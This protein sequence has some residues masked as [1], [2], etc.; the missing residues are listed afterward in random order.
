MKQIILST[1]TIESIEQ[2]SKALKTI[3]DLAVNIMIKIGA[4]TIKDVLSTLPENLRRELSKEL[5]NI[6]PDA[7]TVSEKK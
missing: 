3:P 7:V 4:S 2:I 1:D 6:N 5:F